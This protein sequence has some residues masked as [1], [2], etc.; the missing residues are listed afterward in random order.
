[1]INA[2]LIFGG[3]EQIELAIADAGA[4]GCPFRGGEPHSDS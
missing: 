2:V 3:N 4:E 1:M